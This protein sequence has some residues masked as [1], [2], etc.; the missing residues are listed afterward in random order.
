MS[1][2]RA[3]IILLSMFLLFSLL[4]NLYLLGTRPVISARVIQEFTGEKY[5]TKV[6]DGD[7]IIVEGFPVRLLGI[8]ASE[9]GEKC[10]KE[11]KHRLEELV[12]GKK[13]RLEADVQDKDR[14]GRYLRYVFVGDMNVNL[15][16]VKEGLAI[17]RFQ[18]PNYK[19]KEDI[20]TAEKRAREAGVG[21]LWSGQ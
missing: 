1:G 18:E 13:V 17:A 2:A 19:Y 15:E 20:V 5:V 16:L 8:D 12:L 21:C 10:Y 7:T 11:A 9:K 6:I 4:A 14:Y 3:I